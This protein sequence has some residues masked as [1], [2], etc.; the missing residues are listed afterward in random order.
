[1]RKGFDLVSGQ[2][3]N[4]IRN[5][6]DADSKGIIWLIDSVLGEWNDSVCL[7]DSEKDLLGIEQFFWNCGGA[8]FVLEQESEIGGT[9]AVLA[10][11]LHAGLCTFKRL[12]LDKSLRGKGAGIYLMQW[13]IDWSRER[14][15]RKIEF[16]SD[17]RFERAH[18]F[19]EKF[20]FVKSG[21][22]REMN[23]SH[24]TYWEYYFC[25]DIER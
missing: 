2:F 23:D 18:Q 12:Y 10:V 1:M 7:D 17:T 14:G 25:K 20:G 8:F 3:V 24:E 6:T 16:W 15:F 5:A 9:H 21:E 11:G 22:P 13:N 4:Q 19:F